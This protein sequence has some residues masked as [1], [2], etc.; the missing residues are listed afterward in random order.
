MIGL[1]AVINIL[2]SGLSDL[3]FIY[4]SIPFAI[5]LVIGL[6]RNSKRNER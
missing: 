4:P 3:W 6:L 5:V 1:F 2:T